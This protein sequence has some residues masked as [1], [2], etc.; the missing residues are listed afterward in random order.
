MSVNES[1]VFKA[2]SK[3]FLSRW[4]WPYSYFMPIMLCCLLRLLGKRN[5][6]NE[7][8]SKK[9]DWWSFYPNSCCHRTLIWDPYYGSTKRILKYLLNGPHYVLRSQMICTIST[10]KR[11]CSYLK[12]NEL[13]RLK[14][15]DKCN[16]ID[17]RGMASSYG[18]ISTD[19]ANMF[20]CELSFYE[21]YL[22]NYQ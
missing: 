19:S 2:Y 21:Y 4:E 18:R 15:D 17:F 11:E 12:Q 20:F 10:H 16:P 8:L 22:K 9:R 3:T 13:Q 1:I 14:C 7:T 5:N 6:T